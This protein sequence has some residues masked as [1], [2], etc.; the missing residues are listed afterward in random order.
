MRIGVF[1]GTFDPIHEGHL[2][3]ASGVLEALSLDRVLLVVANMPWQKAG[4]EDQ[5]GAEDRFA[6]VSA[7][8]AGIQGLE[9]SRIEVDRGGITYTADTLRELR[10]EIPDAELVVVVGSDVAEDMGSWERLDEIAELATVAV[11]G[12]GS[13]VTDALLRT[14]RGRV[15][16]VRIPVLETSSSEVRARVAAGLDVEGL[17]PSG[18]A[19]IIHRNALYRGPGARKLPSVALVAARAAAAKALSRVAVLD[20]SA[21]ST[22]CDAFVIADGS[23]SRQVRAVVDEVEKKVKE[24]E[25]RGPDQVEGLE[26]CRWVLMDYGDVLIH[27][28][29]EGT[30]DFYSLES[31]WGDAP[32]MEI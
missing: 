23:N 32:K 7:A 22:F 14:L 21:L 27:V 29:G 16:A 25:G 3:A 6:M 28:F 8:V 15:E 1:G 11:V 9:A 18:V 30:R 4:R 26:A 19:R 2:V 24:E 31:L 12:R 5:A 17:V 13:R 20:M 10:E